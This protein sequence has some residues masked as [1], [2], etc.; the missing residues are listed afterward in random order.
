MRAKKITLKVQAVAVF[1][2]HQNVFNVE[3]ASVFLTET[4]SHYIPLLVCTII[5]SPSTA[6]CQLLDFTLHHAHLA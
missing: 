3:I 2:R 6:G 5:C 1:V 4:S